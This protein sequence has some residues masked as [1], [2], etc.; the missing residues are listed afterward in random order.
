MKCLFFHKKKLVH[1]GPLRIEIYDVIHDCT[2][3]IDCYIARVKL[4]SKCKIATQPLT[5]YYIYVL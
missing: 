2:I 1:F 4:M 5:L 3:I